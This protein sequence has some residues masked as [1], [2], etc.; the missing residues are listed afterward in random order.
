[1]KDFEGLDF[2][3]EEDSNNKGRRNKKNEELEKILKL[4]EEA[5]KNFDSENLEEIINFYFENN[6]FEKALSYVNV[7]LD[8]YPYSTEAW[9]K[10]ALIL[11][12]LGKFDEAI[13]YFDK[14][15]L[16]DP[17]DTEIYINKGITLDN[18][19]KFEQAIDTFLK[20]LEMEPENID[21]S[22]TWD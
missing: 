22:L 13:E 9:H 4:E 21:A 15:I 1:M 11:D 10:K 2:P 14:A 17:T 12:S 16:L 6:E 7:L 8:I 5:K 19:E 18:C 20:A 3:G